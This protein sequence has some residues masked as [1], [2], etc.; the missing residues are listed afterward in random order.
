LQGR[1]PERKGG[2]KDDLL[3]Q[4]RQ[5]SDSLAS[6]F[7]AAPEI[8]IQLGT[9]LG[10]QFSVRLQGI[11][12]IAYAE[13]P[14]FPVS[15]VA[16][17][18][19]RL[20]AATCYGRQLAVL[21]GRFHYYEGY[22][23]RRLTFPLRVLNLMGAKFLVVCNTAGGLNPEF[24]PGSLMLIRDH[25]NFIPDNPLRGANIDEWGPRFPDMSQ[26]YDPGLLDLAKRIAKELREDTVRDGVY[27]AIPGPSLETPAETGFLRQCGADAVG[28]STAPEVIIARHAGMRVLGISVIANVNDP[29]HMAPIVLDDVLTRARMASV[30]LEGLLLAMLKEWP[31]A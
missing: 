28:M 2:Q 5:A 8:V 3:R 9:G 19:G 21:Q 12:E 20:I 26:A 13:I 29:A 25:L 14:H 7:P 10:G 15:T 22:S 27:V 24:S 4:T 16:G 11:K 23:A 1:H 31:A 17:H 30:S 18:E 6:F